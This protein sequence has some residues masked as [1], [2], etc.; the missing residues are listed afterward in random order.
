MSDVINAQNLNCRHIAKYLDKNKFKVYSLSVNK[1]KKI[2]G[3]S[4]L[5]IFFTYKLFKRLGFLWGILQCD[6]DAV[7]LLSVEV[8]WKL[9]IG[10]DLALLF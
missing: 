5:R 7:E 4:V 10:K 2:K 9:D 6:V 3:V 1:Q 8:A